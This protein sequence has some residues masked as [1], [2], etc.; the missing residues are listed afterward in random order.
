MT[1][2]LLTIALALFVVFG[3]ALLWIF[4]TPVS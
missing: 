4:G 1:N 3:L 2:T